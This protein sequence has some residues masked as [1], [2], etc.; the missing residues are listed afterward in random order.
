MWSLLL[1]FVALLKGVTRLQRGASALV[2]CS[3]N[4]LLVRTL[5]TGSLP[6]PSD[7]SSHAVSLTLEY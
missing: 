1:S 2:L 3:I 4:H 6:L 7:T 5:L